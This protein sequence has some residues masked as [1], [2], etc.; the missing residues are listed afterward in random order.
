M[1]QFLLAV[2]FYFSTCL[3]LECMKVGKIL[4]ETV[5]VSNC[6]NTR[7][8]KQWFLSHQSHI[9]VRA[10]ERLCRWLY[11]PWNNHML[12]WKTS[13]RCLIT[14]NICP[15]IRWCVSFV[16]EP[17]LIIAASC[18]EAQFSKTS[19]THYRYLVHNDQICRVT[20]T[21]IYTRPHII[22]TSWPGAVYFNMCAE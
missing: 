15:I 7:D 13:T 10:L 2:T 12:H 21:N 5:S 11:T 17:S 4:K 22:S 3:V 8:T 1:F 9:Q 20:P 19:P 14:G 16:S 18:N 6:S